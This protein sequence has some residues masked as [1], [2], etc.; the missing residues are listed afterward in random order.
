MS[1]YTGASS[2]SASS[3]CVAHAWVGIGT[4]LR[5]RCRSHA[6]FRVNP[7]LHDVPA[8]AATPGPDDRTTPTSLRKALQ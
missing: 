3:T 8:R 5:R 6:P 2:R 1:G 4:V 7:G